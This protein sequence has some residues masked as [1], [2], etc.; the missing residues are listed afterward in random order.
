M[1]SLSGI[2]LMLLG[3][4]LEEATRGLSPIESGSR[5]WDMNSWTWVDGHGHIDI[6][7]DR[8]SW[9]LPCCMMSSSLVPLCEAILSLL[10]LPT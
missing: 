4:N 7:S 10:Q 2:C 8:A 1:V 5:G 6:S 9:V 3:N